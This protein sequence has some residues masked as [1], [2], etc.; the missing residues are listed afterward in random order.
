MAHAR[1]VTHV[2]WCIDVD[3][4]RGDQ[5]GHTLNEIAICSLRER[6]LAHP[7]NRT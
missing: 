2:V 6:R 5:R 3:A 1:S 7:D 4:V